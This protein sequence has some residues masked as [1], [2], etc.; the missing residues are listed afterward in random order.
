M[1]KS[2]FFFT[3]VILKTFYHLFIQ[4]MFFE[5]LLL[6]KVMFQIQQTIQQMSGT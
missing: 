3:D 2:H 1:I 4:Q 6:H 5:V